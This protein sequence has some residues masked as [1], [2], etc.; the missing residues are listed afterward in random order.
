MSTTET[1]T[2]LAGVR[3]LELGGDS[4]YAI[5]YAT[6]LLAD[7]GADVVIVEEPEGHP[8]RRVC[9]MS[10]NPRVAHHMFE[11]FARGKR[12]VTLRLADDEARP[13]LE[14]LIRWADVIV[15][16]LGAGVLAGLGF[17]DDKL[18]ALR[19]G[20]VVVH[21]SDWGSTGPYRDRPATGITL[22]AAAGWVSNRHEPGLPFVQVGGQMHEWIAGA[23][24]A[25]AVMT[26]RAWVR[27]T[28]ESV[29]ADFSLFE[30]IH[31]T[32]PYTH[33]LIESNA[34]MGLGATAPVYTPFGIRPCRDGWVGINILT[35]QHW[36][37]ACTLMG[38]DDF[39]DKQ[40]E[41]MRGEGDI[42]E[43][44]RRLLS[45]LSERTVSEVVELGQAMRIPVVPVPPG[46]SIHKLAQW[47]ERPFFLECTHDGQTRIEPG[48]P[49]RLRR[50]PAR[51]VG[52][53]PRPGEHTEELLGSSTHVTEEAR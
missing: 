27:R 45:W 41:L 51:R 44:E 34:E 53:A 17:D 2:A 26:G 11:F 49:W 12:S 37:D 21:A 22:Q 40:Q 7:L 6:R 46:S 39:S 29:T 33:L 32:I 4:S 47:V 5:P 42:P 25:A 31:S 50:T 3:V 36:V 35:G 48:P 52:S 16:G 18:R 10:E 1:P 23:Y 9:H 20:A 28:G 43:F 14:R 15:D 13:A 19:S 30:C 8:L 24:I 38:L